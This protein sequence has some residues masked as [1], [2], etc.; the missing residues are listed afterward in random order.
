MCPLRMSLEQISIDFLTPSNSG[1]SY[2]K[3]CAS[4]SMVTSLVPAMFSP[5]KANRQ[6]DRDRSL[7]RRPQQQAQE[8]R[9]YQGQDKEAEGEQV[10][11]G[12]VEEEAEEGRANRGKT[13]R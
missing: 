7:L 2:L 11:A 8:G 13:V 10:A 3:S 9:A 6:G 4:F 12:K 1:R 5:G